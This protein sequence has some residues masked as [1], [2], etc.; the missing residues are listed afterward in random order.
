MDADVWVFNG[1]TEE[2]IWKARP[3]KIGERAEVVCSTPYPYMF[4]YVW[5]DAENVLKPEWV[6]DRGVM[7]SKYWRR[8]VVDEDEGKGGGYPAAATQAQQTWAYVQGDFAVKFEDGSYTFHGRS[9]EVLNVNGILFGTEHIEGAILRDKQL[10]PDSCVGHV[11]VIGYPD[12]VAGQVPMAW[13][14]PSRPEK[15]PD[16]ED[17]TRLWGH[18]RDVIGQL[19]VKFIVCEALPQT[20][21]GKFM[22]RLLSAISQGE[23][24]GDT[25]TI[26]NADCIP[27]LQAAFAK[28]KSDPANR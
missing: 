5:G 14:V 8:T 18:V 28:W 17:F 9:D 20:F 10:N 6:G 27:G 7:L 26:A 24:L 21:S 11:V 1:Q 22:R 16:R 4:R 23:P 13:I 19:Q 2:G 25:S 3:A 15:E 12:E